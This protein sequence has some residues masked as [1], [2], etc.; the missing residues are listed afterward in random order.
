M[1]TARSRLYCL[2]A[3]VLIDGVCEARSCAKAQ[4]LRG[5]GFVVLEDRFGRAGP[6][7][8]LRRRTTIHQVGG[9][10]RIFTELHRSAPPSGARP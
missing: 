7:Y 10:P 6:Y 3:L 4:L 1:C 2:I 5:R 9:R 8:A